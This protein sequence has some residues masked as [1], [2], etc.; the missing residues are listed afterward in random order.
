MTILTN[1][2]IVC[3]IEAIDILSHGIVSRWIVSL[4]ILM[5]DWSVML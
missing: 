3:L 5:D 4:H 2:L 1:W